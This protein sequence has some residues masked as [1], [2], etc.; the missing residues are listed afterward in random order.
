[1]KP[2]LYIINWIL[3]V[4]L[5]ASCGIKNA[6]PSDAKGSGIFLAD[7]QLSAPGLSIRLAA[8]CGSLQVYEDRSTAMGKQI[9]LNLAV[10]PAVSRNPEPDPLFFLTGGPGQAATESYVQL[11][12]AFDRIHQKRDIVLVD[13]RGTGKSNP[14]SCPKA[15]KTAPEDLPDK[16]I[17]N[18]VSLCLK[19]I[20]ANPSLYTTSIA[21][22]DLDDV[23]SALGY[24]QIN[25][26]GV[27]YGTRAALTY[28]ELFPNRVR[29]VILDGVVPQDEP[30]GVH[31]GRD[32]QRALDLIFARCDTQPS[33]RQAFPAIRDEFTKLLQGLSSGPIEISI[34]DPNSGEDTQFNLDG[35]KVTSAVR[36]FSYTPETVALI[37]LLMHNAYIRKEYNSLAAMYLIVVGPLEGS[38]TQGMGYSVLCAEDV[39]FY[40]LEEA[41][42]ANAGTYLGDKSVMQLINICNVWPHASVPASFK[43]PVHSD[44]PVLLL[45]GEADPVTPPAY[46]DRAARTLTN[47]MHIVA[48]GM[49]HNVIYRGCIPRIAADFIEA[50]KLH[51][52]D[53]A[54]I[55][56]IQPMPFFANFSG[57]IP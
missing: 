16:E 35:D 15:S 14:L 45:S 52:L 38:I 57:P 31:I 51:G 22:Q 29:S 46:G 2:I 13:Q 23:R 50:G 24:P 5:L 56:E 53:T 37:P 32:A 8:K 40:S 48:P 27:S 42:K 7:C 28:L 25:L 54:C 47:S 20:D 34:S 36:L 43:T 12:S 3:W 9:N 55:Q 21:M 17:A 19:E 33:C 39:P 30:L 11:S 6:A 44:V 4:G 41:A 49:G 18:W 10:I 26:Y 1:M